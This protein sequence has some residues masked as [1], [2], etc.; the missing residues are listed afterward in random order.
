MDARKFVDAKAARMM[1]GQVTLDFDL[2]VASA[3]TVVDRAGNLFYLDKQSTGLCYVQGN[4]D[5]GFNDS[6]L[7]AS[8]GFAMADEAGFSGFRLS[9]PAQPGKVLRVVI[10]SGMTIKP[11]DPVQSGSVA[12]PTVDAALARTIAGQAY[13]GGS[14]CA[15]V[16][17]QYSHI[18]LW[19]AATNTKDVILE[20][21]SISSSVA[22]GFSVL[23]DNVARSVSA[24]LGT[25][26]KPPL[27]SGVG[28]V[29]TENNA[30][31]QGVGFY[32]G[33]SLSAGA[34]QTVNL[35]EPL[36]LRPGNGVNVVCVAVNVAM[37]ANFEWFEQ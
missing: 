14:Y 2:S 15:A 33:Y 9:W 6:P 30:A 8:P 26:K 34:V 31:Q 12:T 37:S 16:A 36:V 18:Q 4:T 20:A 3:S 10:A 25:N 5:Q 23:S 17:A 11:G 35:R 21:F 7:L 24:G 29:R 19:N 27:G 32:L 22:T 13:M 1:R 28:N